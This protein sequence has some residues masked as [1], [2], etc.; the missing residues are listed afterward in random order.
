MIKRKYSSENVAATNDENLP[1]G[2]SL[3]IMGSRFLVSFNKT[4][5]TE[6]AD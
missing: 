3:H 1:G 4:P 5:G 2:G 6:V